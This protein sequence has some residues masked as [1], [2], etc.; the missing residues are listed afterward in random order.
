MPDRLISHATRAEQL[1]EGW[2]DPTGIARCVRDEVRDVEHAH[3]DT[4][5]SPVLTAR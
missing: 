5:V 2:L 1:P 3:R 4:G